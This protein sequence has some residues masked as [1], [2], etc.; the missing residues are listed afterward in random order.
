MVIADQR[1]RY[2]AERILA[3]ARLQIPWTPP[4]TPEQVRQK[5]ED[6]FM[7]TLLEEARD[8][9]LDTDALVGSEAAAQTAPAGATAGDA[10]ALAGS[11][12]AERSAPP[13]KA[14]ASRTD[15]S[16][17]DSR[18]GSLE[19][20]L[21][22]SL[23]ERV[24]VSVLLGREM[25][26]LPRALPLTAVDVGRRD[27]APAAGRRDG[28]HGF[29]G[30]APLSKNGRTWINPVIFR[31]N[32]GADAKAEPGWLLPLICR[33][34]GVTRKEVGAIRVGPRSSTFENRRRGRQ[35]LCARRA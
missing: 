24:L 23:P 12:A 6:A 27:S 4:P 35:R 14:G 28:A 16:S 34:G 9:A 8:A 5:L 30:D 7:A 29:G 33:R 13:A 2:K 26:R 1:E 25:R 18:P 10:G 32:L 19:D 11:E 15:R 20:R 21:R 31:V 17:R 3:T 22:A